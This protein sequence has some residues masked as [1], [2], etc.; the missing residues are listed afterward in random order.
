MIGEERGTKKPTTLLQSP[1]VAGDGTVAGGGRSMELAALHSVA[2]LL[3]SAGSMPHLDVPSMALL[4]SGRG[5]EDVPE[6]HRWRL[7]LLELLVPGEGAPPRAATLVPAGELLAA[8]CLARPSIALAPAAWQP[9]LAWQDPYP[10]RSKLDADIER[11]STAQ[12]LLGQEEAA[13]DDGTPTATA[14]VME[15]AWNAA[16]DTLAK[17]CSAF[18]DAE[19]GHLRECSEKLLQCSP[20]PGRQTGSGGEQELPSW[21]GFLDALLSYV[22]GIPSGHHLWAWLLDALPQELDAC[23][24]STFREYGSGRNSMSDKRKP[25]VHLWAPIIAGQPRSYARVKKARVPWSA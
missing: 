6:K 20:P 13:R 17:Q 1:S 4:D 25:K 16:L 22:E 21:L 19:D 11:R 18:L 5:E 8:L 15:L 3:G 9:L 14:A 10:W 23:L 2:A 7:W 12:L 24:I